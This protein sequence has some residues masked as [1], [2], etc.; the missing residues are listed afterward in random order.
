MNFNWKMFTPSTLLLGMLCVCVCVCI[1]FSGRGNGTVKLNCES[2]CPKN[3]W[4]CCDSNILVNETYVFRPNQRAWRMGAHDKTKSKEKKQLPQWRKREREKKQ[5]F[6]RWRVEI[7]TYVKNILNKAH[8]WPTNVKMWRSNVNWL[9]CIWNKRICD[10]GVCGL[11]LFLVALSLSL[12]HSLAL[13]LSTEW[14]F[15]QS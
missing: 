7:R 11:P 14:A 1:V 6:L 8:L 2:S 10:L 9:G 5:Q 4:K 12:S 13:L 3:K 15:V